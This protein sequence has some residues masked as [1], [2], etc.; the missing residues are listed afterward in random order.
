MSS[1]PRGERLIITLLGNRNSGKSSLINALTNQEIAIVSEVPGTTTDPVAKRYELLPLGPV[2]FY[3]T[4]GLDDMGELG[5]KRIRA[6]YKVLFKT[7]MAIFVNDG[8]PFQENELKALQRLK[9]MKL[10]VLVIFN[11]SDLRKP[12]QNNIEFCQD[13]DLAWISVSATTKENIT[14][15]KE[16]IIEL[17]PFYLKEERPLVRDIVHSGDRVILVTPIDSSAPKGRLILPQ[18]QVLRDLLDSGAVTTVVREFELNKALKALKSEPDLVITDSQVI[19]RVVNQL[20]PQVPLTTFSIL[21]ARYKGDLEALIKGCQKI[22]ELKDGDRILIAEACSHH[23]QKD[24]IGRTK[25][26]NW[27]KNYTQKDLNF[28]IA[29]GSDFPDNLE[30]YALIIHCGACMLNQKEMNNRI[31]EAERRGVPITNYG[32][33][34][35]KLH[36]Y[37]ERTIAPLKIPFRA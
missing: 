7:D 21:F 30:D 16:K 34:I 15:A 37:F 23:P 32:L 35:S 24:D 26:P 3:D 14:V 25:I 9:E 13:N 17:A 8:S 20:P 29:A 4:A 12:H 18:V 28:D 36:G 5:E 27:L 19:Q 1:T 10:P 2:T 22:D 6:A 33:A 11:K 31:R